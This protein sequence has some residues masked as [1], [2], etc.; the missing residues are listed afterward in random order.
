MDEI[1]SNGN[2]NLKRVGTA[3]IA[4]IFQAVRESIDHLMPWMPWCHP[5]YSIPDTEAY[6]NKQVELWNAQEEF[7]FVIRD[8]NRRFA[9]LCGLN[10]F[11]RIHQFANLGYWLRKSSVGHGYATDGTRLVAQFGLRQLNLRRVEILAAV[12]NYPSQRVA[13]RAGAVCEGIL[14]S[15]LWL[16]DRSLDAVCYSLTAAEM[17]G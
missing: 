12:E 11:N 10:Q 7:S 6:V 16:R 9:G 2:V 15:R 17:P 13:E 8:T 1:L 5:D 4:E 3:D 14:R